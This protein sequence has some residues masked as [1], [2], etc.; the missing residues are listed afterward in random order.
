MSGNQGLKDK[1]SGVPETLLLPLWARAAETKYHRP[2]IR[3]ERAVKLVEQI[4]YDF[5][6]FDSAWKSQLGIA[7]RTKILDA[8]VKRNI[9][10]EPRTTVVNLGAGLDSRFLRVDNGE[11]QW[12]DLDLPEVVAIKRRFFSLSERYH[13]I[14]RSVMDFAW[15]DEIREQGNPIL[16]IAEGLFMYFCEKEMRCLFDELVKRFPGAELLFEMIPLGA[17]GTRR[18][19]RRSCGFRCRVQLVVNQQ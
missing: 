5:R 12:Y 17:V 1:L 8:A 2:I 4:D 6:R 14:E 7:V 3:D 15:M 11:I 10:K 19:P 9:E 18:F 13:L 16:I